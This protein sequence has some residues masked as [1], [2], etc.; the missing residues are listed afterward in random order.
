VSQR[1]LLVIP[2]LTQLNTPYPS[3]A[4]LTG[5]LKGRGYDV[6]QADVGIEMVLALFS[7]AGLTRVFAQLRR[8]RNLPGEARQMLALERQYVDAVEAVVTFLQGRDPTLASRICQGRFLPEGPRFSAGNDLKK[9]AGFQTLDH[10][11]HLATLYLEDLADLVHETLAPQFTLS[12]YAE[13]VAR[14]AASFDAIENALVEPPSLTDE[15]ML[16]ALWRHVEPKNPSLVGLTVPFPGNLYGALRIGQSLKA[17]CPSVRIVLG[18]GYVNTELRRLSDPRV[19]DYVD[20]ITLDDGELPLLCLL[21]HLEGTRPVEDLQRTFLRSEGQV[22][23][24]DGKKEDFRMA[25]LGTPTYTGLQLD[26]YISILDTLNPMHRLWSDGHWNKLTVAHGCY[27]KQCTFCDVGLDYIGRYEATPSEILTDRIEALIAETGRRG[28]HFVD[29]A[30]PPAGLKAV[31]LALL[32]RG[33][34]ITWWGNIRFEQTFTPDLCRLLAASG[35]IAVSAGLEAASDRLL[36]EMKKG[37]T[38]DQAARVAAAFNAAGIMVHA[39]LMYGMPGES[40]TETVESLERVRQLFAAG[41]IQSAFWH[42]FTATAHSPIGLD[43]TAHGI[44]ILGPSFSGFAENDLSHQD[45]RGLAPEWLGEGL[46]QAVW[47]YKEGQRLTADVRSW[48]DHPVQRSKVPRDWAART[49]AE[50]K[51]LEEDSRFRHR[52]VSTE[53]R[54]ALE[55]K[56]VWVGGSPVIAS[57][58]KQLWRVILPSHAEDVELRLPTVKAEWLVDLVHDATPSRKKGGEKYPSLQKVR[59]EYPFGGARAFDLMIRSTS[60]KKARG[61]GLLLV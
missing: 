40:V 17:R 50:S 55:R 7:R 54:Y 6:M 53:G 49:I 1:L 58:G 47:H 52:A 29:E 8:K 31:A 24:R 51:N 57:G 45:P 26:R 59:M 32:E 19:F 9:Q 11:R 48:F 56:F 10:A 37:V 34:T 44:R 21:E 16:D 25:E 36:E 5:F 39:Y 3:T 12:R 27:W 35:C 33:I 20:Y 38:V 13:H 46:R 14:S 18:G 42:K 2:P 28:F 60:W 61:G 22:V 41:L 15:L 4:Y 23:W 43:P 30:A